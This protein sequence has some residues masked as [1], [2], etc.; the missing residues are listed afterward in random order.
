V[1]FSVKP[2]GLRSF[3]VNLSF[4]CVTLNLIMHR[5]VKSWFAGPLIIILFVLL[6]NS[7]FLGG[8]TNEN[9]INI[10]TQLFATSSKQIISGQDTLDPNDGTITQALGH[11]AAE[12]ILHGHMP[13]WNYNEQVGAPLAGDMQSASLFPLTL[14]LSLSNGLLFFRIISEIIAGVATYYLILKLGMKRLTAIVFGIAFAVNGSFAWFGSPNFNTIAFLPLLLLG[15]ETA[16]D[17]AIKNKKRGWLV[18]VVALAL[19]LYSGFPEEVYLGGLLAGLWAI[20]RLIQLR[21]GVWR[22][23]LLKLLCGFTVGLLIAAPI[24]IAFL[25]YLQHAFIGSHGSPIANGALPHSA[26][27][28]FFFPYIYGTLYQSTAFSPSGILPSIW[29]ISGGYITVSLLFFAVISLFEKS[30]RAIKILLAA[31]VVVMIARIYSLAGLTSIFHVIPEMSKVA[32]FRYVEPLVELAVILLAAFGFDRVVNSKKINKKHCLASVA[33]VLGFGIFLLAIAERHV[34]IFSTTAPLSITITL[35]WSIG[36]LVLIIASLFAPTNYR[37]AI[38]S[39]VLVLDV[40]LLFMIPQ[41]SAPRTTKLDTTPVAFL[42][43]HVGMYRMFTLGPLQPNYNSYYGIPSI[44]TDNLPLPKTWTNY[45]SSSLD[46]NANVTSFAGVD[47]ATPGKLTPTGYFLTSIKAYENVGVKYVFV[48][49]SVFTPTDIQNAGLKLVFNSQSGE[50]YQLPNP[51][52][53]FEITNGVCYIKPISKSAV[54]VNCA[55]PSQLIRRE[56]YIPGWTAKTNSKSLAI[57]QSGPLFQSVNLPAG[58]HTVH[59]NYLPPYMVVG[60]ILFALGILFTA[61]AYCKAP[62]AIHSKS[63]KLA[64]HSK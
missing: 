32:I 29:G 43:S 3:F 22:Q 27:P 47:P 33:I 15:L 39:T 42:Q 58:T 34:H 60:Y 53:Y 54:N 8:L 51:K 40:L 64:K 35:A 55:K 21:H 24:L 23:F 6:A 45:I 4:S 63:Y 31:W 10:R 16:F 48:S 9:P 38:C 14:I 2:N 49:P 41:L 7:I 18:L 36:C 13:W 11:T 59:F 17:S 37:K 57:T 5:L 50:I 30:N 12:Q 56:L 1:R 19:S 20:V 52:P 25:G 28:M 62:L 61:V 44:N 26:L 46:P